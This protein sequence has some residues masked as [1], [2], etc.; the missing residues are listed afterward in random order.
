MRYFCSLF[1]LR[2]LIFS[3]WAIFLT[4]TVNHQL[5]RVFGPWI[6]STITELGNISF[7]KIKSALEAVYNV[8]LFVLIITGDKQQQTGAFI[9]M[10]LTIV[11]PI[12]YQI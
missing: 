10:H 11:V 3:G 7:Y 2:I 8:D 6:I 1:V 5:S 4:T 9:L 12:M